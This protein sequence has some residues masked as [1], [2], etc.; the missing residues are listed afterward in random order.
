MKMATKKKAWVIQVFYSIM[1]TVSNRLRK[2]RDLVL[3]ELETLG[4]KVNGQEN[5]QTKMRLGMIIKVLKK[6]LTMYLK[7]MATGG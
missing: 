3:L 2:L 6:S 7:M 4:V 1:R 5:L